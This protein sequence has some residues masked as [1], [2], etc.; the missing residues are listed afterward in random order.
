MTSLLDCDI[1]LLFGCH[2][3]GAFL[4]W[5]QLNTMAAMVFLLP[6]LPV[7]SLIGVV[8]MTCSSLVRLMIYM[9]VDVIGI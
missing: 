8:M 6:S 1:W 4:T 5:V 7:A 3:G 2:R 9:H